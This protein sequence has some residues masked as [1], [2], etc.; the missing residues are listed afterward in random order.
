MDAFFA[1]I[2]QRDNP[3]LRGKPVIVG[4]DPT[5]RGVVCAASYEARRFG[6]RSA[7]PIGEAF[8]RC[9]N[10]A[11][12]RPRMKVYSEESDRI[13]GIL[14]TFSPLVEPVSV[15]EAFLDMTGTRRLHGPPQSSAHALAKSITQ[16]TSLTASIGIAPN[17][18]L[19]KIASDCNK[20]AGI[21]LVPKDP[22]EIVAWLAPMDVGKIWG[23]GKVTQQSLNQYGIR[24]IGDLQA[25][26]EKMLRH[27][28][29]NLGESLYRLCRG[30]DD[31]NVGLSEDAK[32]ISR[33]YTFDTD[34]SDPQ[35][36]RATLLTCAA[37]VSRRARA[38]FVAGATVV[39]IYRTPAFTKHTRR[40]GLL[41]ATNLTRSIY[42]TACTLFEQILLHERVFR[43]VGLGITGLTTATQTDLFG[44]PER[45]R[46]EASEAAMDNVQDRFGKQV[47]KRGAELIRKRK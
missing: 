8:R 12:V 16:T 39:F 10:G 30:I 42:D 22:V 25:L 15:D 18:F 44:E 40:A 13:M 20:P 11:F 4:A 3:L 33:E 2:E 31:R 26:P 5:G 47:I 7:M 17:K 9:P 6:I 23:V 41:S 29:G 14:D 32:S 38:S 27:N 24:T 36:I 1:S 43:L 46:V 45:T 19:A 28:F 35:Q 37:D 34:C 21:T